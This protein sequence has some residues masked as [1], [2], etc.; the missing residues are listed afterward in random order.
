MGEDTQTNQQPPPN[1]HPPEVV[2]WL[3]ENAIPIATV[4]PGSGTEDLRPLAGLFG[5]ARIVSLGEAS[6]G[7]REFFQLKHRILEL[8]V[9]ELGFD[10]FV[11]EAAFAESL[12]IDD[13]VTRGIG[14]A[15]A[16][17]AGMRFWTWDTEEVLRLVE[18]MRSHNV[19]R[20][21]SSPP[22]RYFGYDMQTPAP[23]A[24]AL[25]A[26]L[27]DREP[28]LGAD[29]LRDLAPLTS[30][31]GASQWGSLPE[32]ARTVAW[33]ALDRIADRVQRAS[34]EAD[35]LDRLAGIHAHVLK[36]VSHLLANPQ[37][38]FA[39]RDQT[40]AENTR[41]LLELLGPESKV[42]GW[43]HNAHAQRCPYPTMNV[44]TMGGHLHSMFGDAQRIVGFAFGQGTVQAVRFPKDGLRYHTM[45][46]A[47]EGSIEAACSEVG[48]PIFAVDLHS[49]PSQGPVA[50]W[51]ASEPFHRN[52]GA[53]YDEDQEDNFY[54][55]TD[56]R[57]AYDVLIFVADATAAR[58]NPSGIR[59]TPPL[60]VP[61]VLSEPTNLEFADCQPGDQPASWNVPEPS[62]PSPYLVAVRPG[63][64]PDGANL[65]EIARPWSVVPWGNCS[66]TQ[67]FDAEPYRGKRIALRL[68]VRAE[69]EGLGNQAE[70]AIAVN[71]PVPENMMAKMTRRPTSHASTWDS[72]ITSPEWSEIRLEV[73][74]ADDAD[75]VLISLDLSGNGRAE[76]SN[77][78][79]GPV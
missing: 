9:E 28:E 26:Y 78:S 18:W 12:P 45:P 61:E 31:F 5:A 25:I 73:D 17:V 21:G 49:A 15:G 59:P 1:H 39:V 34:G 74:L 35:E 38:M 48:L 79:I 47:R 60:S 40:M 67:S 30:D 3:V 44:K 11:L 13:Y 22:I 58:R 33:E 8:C 76:F 36:R 23:S 7:T 19:T 63:G 29:A 65:L 52:L 4:E 41:S 57:E 16:G 66:V 77:L 62:G 32:K 69:V 51:L 72:P 68:Q 54:S 10:A 24:R 71:G 14:S 70:G 20:A 50:D 43:A 75:S 55:R 42:V 46:A 6:H 37:S 56:P 27:S 2:E 53:F 64:A